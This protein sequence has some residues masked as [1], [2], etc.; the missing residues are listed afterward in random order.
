MVTVGYVVWGAIGS[1]VGVG[2]DL[3]SFIV[4]GSLQ[5]N[6]TKWWLV[7]PCGAVDAAIYFTVF[8]YFAIKKFNIKTIGREDDAQTTKMGEILD[9]GAKDN[10]GKKRYKATNIPNYLMTQKILRLLGG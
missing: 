2:G 10:S 8:Y 9:M 3:I 1:S 6:G 7:F 4:Y 5:G